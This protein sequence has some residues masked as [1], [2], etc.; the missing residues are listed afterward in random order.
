MQ[1]RK[2]V[3]T[4]VGYLVGW[5][6]KNHEIMQKGVAHIWS[7]MKLGESVTFIPTQHVKLHI[8]SGLFLPKLK[9][10]SLCM[11]SKNKWVPLTHW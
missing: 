3:K 8:W 10:F 7:F 11:F 6:C 4:L 2:I 1:R 5:S 9:G